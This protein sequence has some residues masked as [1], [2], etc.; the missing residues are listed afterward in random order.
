MTSPTTLGR[1]PLTIVELEQPRCSL[2][3][4]VSPCTASGTP[5]CYQTSGTCL[6]LPN[7][8]PTGSIKWRF[9]NA[10]PGSFSMADF[11]D[12]D[13]PELPPIPCLIS[14]ST[15][16]NEINAGANLDNRAPLG[17][18][19]KA[20]IIMSDLPWNDAYGDFYL[21]DR[22]GYVAGKP[23][24]NRGNY[25]A[26]WTARNLFF[27]GMYVRIYDGYVGQTL[28]AMRQRLYIL[29]KVDG[30]DGDGKTTLTAL[31]P[32]RLASDKKAEFPRTSTLDLYGAVNSTTTSI[33]VFGDERDLSD[34]FGNTGSIKYLSIGEELIRYNGYTDIGGGQY[35]LTGVIR[36]ALNSV[37]ASHEDMD[38]VQRAGRYENLNYW[39]VLNDLLTKHTEMPASFIPLAAWNAE[40]EEY[41]PTY[42]TTRTIV[43]PTPV[44]DLASELTQQGLFYIWWS[45]YE[46]ELKMLAVRAPETAPTVLTDDKNLMRGAVLK[47]DP[48]IRLTQ[49]AVYYNE[50]NPFDTS[51]SGK[52]YNNRFTAIDGENLAETRAK[53]IFAPW[54]TNRTQ[55]VQLAVR[56]LIRYRAVP[57]FLTVTIDAKDREAV[58]GSVL[59][60]ETRAIVT[61]EGEMN[62][63]RWQVISAK[64]LVAGHTYLLNCQ[65]YE[66]LGRFG[67]YMADGS[68]DYTAATE[69][70][71]ATGAWYAADTGLMS[72]GTEGY[73]YQ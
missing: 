24:P 18:T 59:D 63:K 10:R 28:A 4:G 5:K 68:P 2:R 62:T 43:S 47:R 37:A 64:E 48:S 56:L 15:S 8:T 22:T 70:E 57:Q 13:N 41:L 14:V 61:S 23:P 25:W 73:K 69:E 11:S 50:I 67:R 20:T 65:T 29:D 66:F 31:D 21:A 19:S 6:D 9:I 58:V 39:L 42:K 52:N 17:V 30:P 53:A 49:V 16:E 54:I 45:E 34:D 12:P 38:K 71:R 51:G 72:D 46:Q 33:T 27:T 40:G 60:I 32:L 3:F 7:Y 55:A 1:E 26:L 44:I 36:G 35:T